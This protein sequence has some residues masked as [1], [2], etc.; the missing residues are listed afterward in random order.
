M[1]SDFGTDVQCPISSCWCSTGAALQI[2]ELPGG[3]IQDSSPPGK[4]S[5]VKVA[6]CWLVAV[7][8]TFLL[9]Y[10]WDIASFPLTI[11]WWH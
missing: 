4:P 7:Q 9:L 3:E 8:H 1:L 6:D 5:M 2:A 10:I 11:I